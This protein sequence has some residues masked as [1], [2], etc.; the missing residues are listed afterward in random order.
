MRSALIAF[1]T[2]CS[3]TLVTT[4]LFVGLIFQGQMPRRALP[5][6]L[7]P[8]CGLASVLAQAKGF[9]YHFHPVSLGLS[10]QWLILVVWLWERVRATSSAR[11]LV[12]LVPAITGAVL[13]IRVALLMPSSPYIHSLWL[14]S[15]GRD[16]AE[17]T[18]RDYLVYFQTVDFF[19]WELR[20]GA[21]FIKEHTLPTDTVQTYGMDPY[22]LF[23]AERMSATPYIYAYDLNADAALAGGMLPAPIGLHPDGWQSQKIRDLRDAH[24]RDM[25]ERLKKARPAAFVFHDRSPLITWQDAVVDFGEHCKE[26]AAWVKSNY[27]ETADFQGVRVWMRNDLAAG[28]AFVRWRPPPPEADAQP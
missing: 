22:I 19:P 26:S 10:L 20:L 2:L 24:E 13:A 15:K 28:I 6:A 21:K 4:T 27:R 7:M 23:L 18:S 5:F 3:L 9:P 17:R 11:S 12:R 8:V 16:A 25:L 1:A 14:H